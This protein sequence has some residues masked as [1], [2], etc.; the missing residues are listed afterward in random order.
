MN[1]DIMATY[2]KNKDLVNEILASKIIDEPTNQLVK[3]FMLMTKHL[4]LKF[5][6]HSDDDK[7]DSIQDAL[8]ALLLYWRNF[9]EKN[10]T[11]AFAYYT[12]IIKRSYA[13]SH[14][15]RT[16]FDAIDISNLQ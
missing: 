4:A 6:F 7:K 3:Y 11:N 2:C 15:K 9:D 14:K 1:K 13:M 10:Y 16:K 8:L 5:T 12:E